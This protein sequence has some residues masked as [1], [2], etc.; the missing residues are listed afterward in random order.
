MTIEADRDTIVFMKVGRHAG[1]TFDEILERKRREYERAGRIFWGY[2]G[3][4]MH[5]TEKVQ[6]F[7]RMH[8]RRGQS[9]RLVM[10]EI[11]SQH[12]NTEV[13]ATHYSKDGV[14][15]ERMPKDVHVRGSR[16]ALVLD[17]I[18]EGDLNLDLSEYQVGVGPSAGKPAADYIRGRVDKGCL[19]RVG[20][21]PGADSTSLAGATP[22]GVLYTEPKV[23][24]V[25]YSAVLQEPYAV[26]LKSE[27]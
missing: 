20:T 26:L 16:Y 10:Q 17:Q 7:V 21:G 14:T 2:G 25:K 5:P 27:P 1:E 4:T 9:V 13:Y 23:V 18:E 12:P 24:P 11:D 19:E 6:P 3:G 22:G 15:W 8:L